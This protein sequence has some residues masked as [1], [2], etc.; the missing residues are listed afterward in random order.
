MV[1]PGAVNSGEADAG[2]RGTEPNG[3]KR[4]IKCGIYSFRLSGETVATLL[5]RL[6]FE[7]GGN[8]DWMSAFEQV[9]GFPLLL[10]FYYI[11]QLKNS[12]TGSMDSDSDRPTAITF[13]LLYVPPWPARGRNLS[14]LLIW[15]VKPCYFFFLPHLCIPTGLQCSLLLLPQCTKTHP[16]HHQLSCPSHNLLSPPCISTR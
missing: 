6:Y 15:N 4:W 10:P 13:A 7:K 3:H 12:S 8:S 1:L 9:A 2:H 16:I 11:S 14:A 5:G